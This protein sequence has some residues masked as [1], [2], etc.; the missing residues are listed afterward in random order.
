[1]EMR[2][3]ALNTRSLRIYNTKSIYTAEWE[4]KR[5]YIYIERLKARDGKTEGWGLLPYDGERGFI[6]ETD[7]SKMAG[8]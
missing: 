3:K 8:K 4:L 7:K 5:G 2:P 1:M 6:G